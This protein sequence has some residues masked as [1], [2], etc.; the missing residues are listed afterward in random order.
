MTVR[1]DSDWLESVGLAELP[2]SERGDFIAHAYE[3]LQ[4]RV[5]RV[6]VGDMTRS[7]LTEFEA[8]IAAGDDDG[9]LAWLESHTRHYRE[10]VAEQF[11]KL[12]AEVSSN[13]SRLLDHF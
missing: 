2:P 13:A 3:M 5:G 11:E 6:L 7:E 9:A 12:S 8:L 4:E 1:L 10:V